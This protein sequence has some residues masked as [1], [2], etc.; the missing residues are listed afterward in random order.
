MN[1]D[2]LFQNYITMWARKRAEGFFRTPDGTLA[3]VVFD[4]TTGDKEAWHKAI[5]PYATFGNN[6][7]ASFGWYD[8]IIRLTEQAA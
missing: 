4:K 7:E 1:D 6:K 2:I 8:T 5:G 3:S